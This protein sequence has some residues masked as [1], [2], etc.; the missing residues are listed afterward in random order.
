MIFGIVSVSNDSLSSCRKDHRSVS[1][2]GKSCMRFLFLLPVLFL[3]LAAYASDYRVCK[4]PPVSRYGREANASTALELLR[5]KDHYSL[6]NGTYEKRI[7]P[8]L[9]SKSLR[10]VDPLKLAGILESRR[11]YIQ[12]GQCDDDELTL[13]LMP[14]CPG[15]GP[16]G[17]FA[18]S[19]IGQVVGQGSAL[20]AG[21]TIL[22]GTKAFIRVTA[23]KE[24]AEVFDQT[25][26]QQSLPHL[27]RVA[28]NIGHAAAGVGA[29]AGGASPLP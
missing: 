27:H 20:L 24:A 25:L 4:W 7:R 8:E 13:E 6:S 21:Y 28:E 17:V 14:R 5:H 26:V 10:S 2:E 11:A 18:G 22:Y 3:N 16:G 12:I 29:V 23:G 19:V 15:A 9:V 1:H